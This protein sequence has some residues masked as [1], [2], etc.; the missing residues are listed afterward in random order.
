[1]LLFDSAWLHQQYAIF[2]EVAAL[3][4]LAF[5]QRFNTDLLPDTVSVPWSFGEDIHA[6]ILYREPISV[7]TSCNLLTQGKTKD[8]DPLLSPVHIITLENEYTRMNRHYWK[9]FK[10]DK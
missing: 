8:S 1:M 10:R 6:E 3:G 5:G 9:E 7:R 2:H 4:R